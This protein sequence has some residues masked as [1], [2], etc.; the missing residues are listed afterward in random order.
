MIPASLRGRCANPLA[1]CPSYQHNLCFH[2]HQPEAWTLLESGCDS[3]SW[4]RAHALGTRV[5][6]CS[7]LSLH[8]ALPSLG[9]VAEAFV[10]VPPCSS[11]QQWVPELILSCFHSSEDGKKLQVL[12]CENLFCYSFA[13]LGPHVTQPPLPTPFSSV[14]G[15]HCHLNSHVSSSSALGLYYLSW[16]LCASQTLS[17]FPEV[18][19]SGLAVPASLFPL[20]LPLACS[21]SQPCSPFHSNPSLERGTP[22]PKGGIAWRAWPCFLDLCSRES[23][24]SE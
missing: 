20:F 5:C 11:M 22:G 10:R 21:P 15:L 14:L 16:A 19:P 3:L 1:W 4:P 6:A 2:S 12:K 23:C 13:V 24:G 17:P 9:S 18:S 8:E 7:T